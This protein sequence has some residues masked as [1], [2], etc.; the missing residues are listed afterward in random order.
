MLY[1]R[2]SPLFHKFLRSAL[3][4]SAPAPLGS[5]D[6]HEALFHAVHAN[7]T[8]IA[9]DLLEQGANPNS[10]YS[11][12]G[13][14]EMKEQSQDR[15]VLAFAATN[16]NIDLVSRLIQA[17][18]DVDYKCAP[19]DMTALHCAAQGTIPEGFEP[20]RVT[21][22]EDLLRVLTSTPGHVQVVHCA[23]RSVQLDLV[24]FALII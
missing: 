21:T 23:R 19:F 10:A 6:L 24:V 7:F 15:S 17:N 16:G 9:L 14:T 22:P 8:D 5:S 1:H 13:N 3:R 12:T 2:D 4:E 11:V 20:S 18:A